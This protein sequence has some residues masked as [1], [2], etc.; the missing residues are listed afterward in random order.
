[1]CLFG[2]HNFLI[3]HVLAI[4]PSTEGILYVCVYVLVCVHVVCV[5]VCVCVVCVLYVYVSVCVC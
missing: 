2:A 1:M 5:L 4:Y 3:A